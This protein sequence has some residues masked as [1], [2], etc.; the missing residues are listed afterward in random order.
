MLRWDK[1]DGPLSSITLLLIEEITKTTPYK[2]LAK[3]VGMKNFTQIPNE[4][5]SAPYEELPISD[6]ARFLF[7]RM[8]QQN[9]LSILNEWKDSKG[10]IYFYLCRDK[11][12][13]SIKKTRKTVSKYFKELKDNNMI[14]E[15]RQGQNKPNRVYILREKDWMCNNYPSGSVKST[16]PDEYFLPTNNTEINN[17]KKNNLFTSEES[18]GSMSSKK[19]SNKNSHIEYDYEISTESGLEPKIRVKCESIHLEKFKEPHRAIR[20]N[21]DWSFFGDTPIDEIEEQIRWFF[22]EAEFPKESCNYDCAHKVLRDMNCRKADRP[23]L[24]YK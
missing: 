20:A 2:P 24:T 5:I 8:I 10:K 22:Y 13:E 23:S 3:L 21:K 9:S 11:Y 15:V 4:I 17:T 14:N 6:S 18:D 1:A 19:S 16:R 7:I 12:A